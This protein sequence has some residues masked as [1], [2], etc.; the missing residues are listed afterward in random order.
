VSPCAQVALRIAKDPRFQKLLCDRTYADDCI[1]ER[2]PAPPR[3]IRTMLRNS[4]SWVDI[5]R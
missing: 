5:A 1:A 4:P 2:V 3:R